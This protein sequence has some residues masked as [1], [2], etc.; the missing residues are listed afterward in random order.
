MI[1]YNIKMYKILL[2]QNI[3]NNI[4]PQL[5][6]MNHRNKQSVRSISIFWSPCKRSINFLPKKTN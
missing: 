4:N 1:N 2:M 6:F 3:N 5:K